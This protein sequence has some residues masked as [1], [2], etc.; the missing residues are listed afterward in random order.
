VLSDANELRDPCV[1][2]LYSKSLLYLVSRALEPEHKTPVLGLQKAWPNWS[3]GV[4]FMDGYQ[5]ILDAWTAASKGVVLDPPIT[6]TEVPI[7]H[8]T[9]KDETINAGHGSFDNNLNIVNRAIKRV[10]GKNPTEPVT[11]LRGF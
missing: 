3:A 6:E 5:K 10:I 4:D 1:P 11:D 8:E 9:N 7:R 2:V